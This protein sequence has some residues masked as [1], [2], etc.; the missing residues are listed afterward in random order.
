MA[1]RESCT[2]LCQCMIKKQDLLH[3]HKN[4]TK[5]FIFVHIPDIYCVFNIIVPNHKKDVNG[6]PKICGLSPS[7]PV[8]AVAHANIHH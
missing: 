2:H 5:H 8:V 7:L 4:K 1:K 3:I 6:L